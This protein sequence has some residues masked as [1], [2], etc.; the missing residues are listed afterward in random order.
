[1]KSIA[2]RFN[3]FYLGAFLFL[4]NSCDSFKN[5]PQKEVKLLED[6]EKSVFKAKNINENAATIKSESTLNFVPEKKDKNNIKNCICEE[7]SLYLEHLCDTIKLS[8]GSKLYHSFSCDTVR[9]V[10]ENKAERKLLLEEYFGEDLMFAGRIG[11]VFYKEFEKYL[12][13]LESSTSSPTPVNTLFVNKESGK[14]IKVLKLNS[15]IG[16]DVINNRDYSAYLKNKD[17]NIIEIVFHDTG[18]KYSTT[19]EKIKL[20]EMLNERIMYK[21]NAFNP[22]IKKDDI[23]YLPFKCLD[24]NGE[25]EIKNLLIK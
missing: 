11:L 22:I 9:F 15:F 8:N 14:V 2:K 18:E 5:T 7:K 17:S 12:L 1:M 3:I 4:F 23:Y 25:I 16:I 24:D 13:F 10:F 21:N 6:Y 19:F 20:K